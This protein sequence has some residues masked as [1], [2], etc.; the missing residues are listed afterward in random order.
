MVLGLPRDWRQVEERGEV[1][2][3]LGFSCPRFLLLVVVQILQPPWCDK[4]ARRRGVEEVVK[5]L[6]VNFEPEGK[7]VAD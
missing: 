4:R 3:V 7:M 1:C 5:L 2:G 6:N